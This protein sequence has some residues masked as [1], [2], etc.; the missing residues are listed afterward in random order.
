[1]GYPGL[2]HTARLFSVSTNLPIS[3]TAAY[4]LSSGFWFGLSALVLCELPHRLSS[5]SMLP[6]TLPKELNRPS[7][8]TPS[9]AILSR[10]S[11]MNLYITNRPW[12]NTFGRRILTVCQSTRGIGHIKGWDFRRGAIYEVA[13]HASQ[14]TH[15]GI[16]VSEDARGFSRIPRSHQSCWFLLHQICIKEVCCASSIELHLTYLYEIALVSQKQRQYDWPG[17]NIYWI[18]WYHCKIPGR[19]AFVSILLTFGKALASEYIGCFRLQ[20]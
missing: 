5:D 1:M 19:T 16:V 12:P 3:S 17:I 2:F 10:A 11:Q 6:R 18:T 9:S 15:V 4:A 13:A 14:F 7:H 20:G 8:I